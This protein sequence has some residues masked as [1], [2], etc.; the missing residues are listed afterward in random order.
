MTDVVIDPGQSS[1]VFA[2][3]GYAAGIL[4]RGGVYRSEDGG[5]NWSSLQ[6]PVAGAVRLALA[7]HGG[8]I[9]AATS[10]GVY[11]RSVE[12]TVTVSPRGRPIRQGNRARSGRALGGGATRL[13]ESVAERTGFEPVIEV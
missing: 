10:L 2:S 11:E 6:L 13:F 8:I 3:A 1:S 4:P 7:P 12:T 5:R 9:Y